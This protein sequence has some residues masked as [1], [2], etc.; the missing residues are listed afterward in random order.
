MGAELGGGTTFGDAPVQR[1]WFLGGAGS[2]RGYPAS[3]AI[4][5]S[6]ARAR[7]EIART[8]DGIGSV[9]VFGDVGW[10]G[11]RTLFDADDFLYAIGVGGSVLDG[12]FRMDLSR[13]LKGPAREFRIDLYLD[14]LM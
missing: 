1:S 3:A 5:T 8:F 7:L 9:G 4:G 10:A 13:G 14:A 6:F 11:A 2:L 12:L